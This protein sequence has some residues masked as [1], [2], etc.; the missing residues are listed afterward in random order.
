MAQVLEIDDTSFEREVLRAETPVL[1]D[2][3]ARWCSP[4]RALAP[5]L[6]QLAAAHAGR[7]AIR[8]VDGD[9]HPMLAGRYGVRAF[10]TVVAFAGGEDVGRRVGLTTAPKL[11]ELVRP[12]LDQSTATSPQR[13]TAAEAAP[14]PPKP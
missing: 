9:R 11:L 6:D 13:M 1:V 8:S 3:T 7:L 10:P 12:W 14:T 4:C 2:F 5:I